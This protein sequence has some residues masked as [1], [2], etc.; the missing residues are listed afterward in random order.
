[1]LLL[2]LFGEG[3][4]KV[5]KIF[6]VLAAL[7]L[8]CTAACEKD[9]EES[10]SGTQNGTTAAV[11][12]KP[13][14]NKPSDDSPV[15]WFNQQKWTEPAGSFEGGLFHEA[16]ALPIDLRELDDIAAPY[17]MFAGGIYQLFD[18]IDTD[19]I[20]ELLESE[21]EVLPGKEAVIAVLTDSDLSKEERKE[22]LAR[23]KEYGINVIEICNFSEHRL[24]IKS[25]YENGWWRVEA[26]DVNALRTEFTE[27]DDAYPKD[28]LDSVVRK[29]GSPTYLFCTETEDDFYN[30]IQ[31]NDSLVHYTLV[32]EYP[33][34]ALLI[35]M[36]EYILKEY[37]GKTYN[38]HTAEITEVY[39]Y[40]AECWEAMKETNDDHYLFETR[41]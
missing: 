14:E 34:Y 21:E 25:C 29:F 9:K 23:Q 17:R 27:S 16:I 24:S 32:Y 31:E 6:F 20:G 3:G 33:E 19:K 1:M 37:D 28:L 40:S 18:Y 39:Y 13:E 11:S 36:K 41:K 22:L 2:R 35:G 12:V 7:L 30:K 26:Y 10:S 4:G 38:Q 5:K 8:F 15:F